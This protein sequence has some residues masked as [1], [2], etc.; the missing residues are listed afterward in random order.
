[1]RTCLKA[2]V[3]V[4]VLS[5]A[6]ASPALAQVG[7][8]GG[9][10]LATLSVSGDTEGQKFG[11]QPGVVAGGF[12]GVPLKKT[13]KLSLRIEALFS[14]KG[15]RI[16]AEGVTDS[17]RINEIEIPVLAT[18]L[19]KRGASTNIRVL[20]GPAFGV[21]A[22]NSDS[23]DGQPVTKATL[24]NGEFGLKVGVQFEHGKV[25]YGASY[26]HGVTNMLDANDTTDSAVDAIKT[27][28]FAIVVGWK[29]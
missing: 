14:Q 25:F 8:M 23:I 13:A 2:A 26:T 27:R 28:T 7:I 4:F 18:F 3:G 10:N 20:A 6:S 1:V 17:A 5:I 15:V 16:E 29:K 21:Y 9:V 12:F 11:V 19:V 22:T 24:A